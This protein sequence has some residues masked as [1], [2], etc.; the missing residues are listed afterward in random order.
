MMAWAFE[1]LATLPNE[2]ML[3][4]EDEDLMF[5]ADAKA[6]A[7]AIMLPRSNTKDPRRK[8]ASTLEENQAD[9]HSVA[10]ST[11]RTDRSDRSGISRTDAGSVESET[12]KMH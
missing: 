6:V 10:G 4:N 8:G 3:A 1:V 12:K 5:V 7:A 9:G 11:G 2:A